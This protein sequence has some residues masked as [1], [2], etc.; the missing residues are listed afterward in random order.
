MKLIGWQE[1]RCSY[2]R[3]RHIPSCIF[4][5]VICQS[6]SGICKRNLTYQQ[7]NKVLYVRERI[8]PP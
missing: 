2:G 3:Y 5:C 6:K 7:E 4:Y 1:W 8:W